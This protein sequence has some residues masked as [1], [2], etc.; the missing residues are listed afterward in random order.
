[1]EKAT[2]VEIGM[3]KCTS[4]VEVAYIMRRIE[5]D[6]AARLAEMAIISVGERSNFKKIPTHTQ[7]HGDA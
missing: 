4:S 3:Y 6:K 1:M 5:E 7:E 2:R